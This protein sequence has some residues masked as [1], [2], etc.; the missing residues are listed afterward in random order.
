VPSGARSSRACRERTR[1]RRIIARGSG[2]YIHFD[3]PELVAREVTAFV[4]R[5]R[6]GR[7][8]PGLGTTLTE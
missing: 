2:H 4:Q 8:Q 5:I 3:R 7:D 6:Q 1:S